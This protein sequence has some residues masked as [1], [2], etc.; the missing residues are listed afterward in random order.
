MSRSQL[1]KF[2]NIYP[3]LMHSQNNIKKY[4][5]KRSKDDNKQYWFFFA[6]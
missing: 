2:N 5:V 6:R 3:I 4:E 1:N